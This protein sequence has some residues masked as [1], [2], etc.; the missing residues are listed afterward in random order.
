[1][2]D[3]LSGSAG[4]DILRG[5]DG[6]DILTGGAGVD[7]FGFSFSALDD[8]TDFITDFSA[9]V[10]GDKLDLSAIHA[11]NIS[12]GNA[13]WAAPS[14]PFTHGYVRI[15]QQ[16]SD[17][18]IGYDRD[19]YGSNYF[20]EPITT[21]SNVDATA[22]T[23]DNFTFGQENF[24]LVRTGFILEQTLLGNGNVTIGLDLWGGAP[25]SNV[26]IVVK[27]KSG[28]SLGSV[29]FTPS[30]WQGQKAISL[31]GVS[32][33]FVAAKDLVFQVVS[34]D[35]DYSTST[36]AMAI[37]NETYVFEKPLLSAP[38]LSI[39]S[40]VNGA[41][42]VAISS[43]LPTNT[44]TSSQVRLVS[45]D[46]PSMVVQGN[47]VL[48][49][50]SGTLSVPQ[51]TLAGTN[52]FVGFATVNGSQLSFPVNIQFDNPNSATV[53]SSAAIIQEGGVVQLQITLAKPAG[54]AITLNWAVSGSGAGPASS[55]DFFM[56]ALPSGS[57][58]FARGETTKLI[59]IST[60]DDLL[61]E[62]VEAF[63]VDFSLATGTLEAF[64][65]SINVLI[66]DNDSPGQSG[67]IT[68]WN[69]A[70]LD[71]DLQFLREDIPVTQSGA[72]GFQNI[73]YDS[74]SK[75][76]TMEFWALPSEIAQNFD[77][78]FELPTGVTASVVASGVLGGWT[79]LSNLDGKEFIVAG[80]GSAPLAGSGTAEIFTVTF[81]NVD[82]AH[83]PLLSSGVIGNQVISPHELYQ[84]VNAFTENGMTNFAADNGSYSATQIQLDAND[85]DRAIDSRDALLALKIANGSITVEDL[86]SPLQILAA[87]VTGNGAVTTLDAWHLLRA[88]VGID[89]ARIG[90]VGLVESGIDLSGITAADAQIALL[91][92]VNFGSATP[93]GVT[94]F[95]V[96]DVDGSYVVI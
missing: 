39:V 15:V 13:T 73:S 59:Q 81:T 41:G 79:F 16:G 12:L 42:S 91:N 56:G 57:V 49:G 35:A 4:N 72:T 75:T 37:I 93:F 34:T 14:L 70:S 88:V 62:Q 40:A 25:A 38:Q 95:I 47:L 82:A 87:D 89:N 29:S 68:Y 78:S 53:T 27:N 44:Q 8:A 32:D 92:S 45:L 51:S 58:S 86:A 11:T 77:L 60:T 36:L 54:E 10:G 64:P 52:R 7:T 31:S 50:T 66:R 61:A 46:D 71:L 22:L 96:G 21:L 63:S 3:I 94:A 20:F 74:V 69:G 83:V 33:T 9:G 5:N 30:D 90:T 23:A 84:T 43:N 80:I 19:G 76:L 65:A 55:A 24:G 1:G 85:I 48:S 18:V 67:A 28:V 17:A 26:Q 2:N 6:A